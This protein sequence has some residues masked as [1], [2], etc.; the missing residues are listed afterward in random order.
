MLITTAD[1]IA[2]M[3]EHIFFSWQ[4]D[5]HNRVGRSFIETCLERAIRTLQAD[6]DIEP[7]NRDLSVDH[8]QFDILWQT[9][10]WPDGSCSFTEQGWVGYAEERNYHV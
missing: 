3:P 1:L 5:V 9:A 10:G 8:E 2:P 7:A 6:A 4:S